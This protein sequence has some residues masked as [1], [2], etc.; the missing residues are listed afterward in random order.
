MWTSIEC[1]VKMIDDLFLSVE[2]LEITS[3][4]NLR[5]WGSIPVDGSSKKTIGG[6]PIIAIDTDNFLLFPPDNLAEQTFS[7]LISELKKDL[8]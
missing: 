7:N 8:I 3:H 6:F 2:I 5:A 1:V 4:M